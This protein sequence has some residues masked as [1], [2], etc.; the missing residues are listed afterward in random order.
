MFGI[1]LLQAGATDGVSRSTHSK[2]AQAAGLLVQHAETLA[3]VL[4]DQLGR[5]CNIAAKMQRWVC[6][7]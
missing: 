3:E 6:E 4:S 1:L 2:Q 5:A 7:A